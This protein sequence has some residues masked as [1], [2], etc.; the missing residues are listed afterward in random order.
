MMIP[1][2]A[3]QKFRESLRGPSL[4]P[5]EPG[6]DEVRAIPNAMINRKPAII[7]RCAGAAD[8]ISC[9]R[10]GREHDLLVSIR[11][12]GHSV[13][14]K[15]VCDDGLMIDLSAMKGI[16]V[17]PARR[18]VRA[19]P[20]LRLGEFDRETQAL[21]L[22]TTMGLLP[23][24]GISGLTLGGG[25]GNLMAKHGLALDNLIGVDVVTADGRLLTASAD[26][27]EDLFWGIRGSSGNLGVVTSLEYRL[28]EV[29]PVLGGPLLYPVN[30]AEEVV[31]FCRDFAETLPDEV[32]LQ[33]GAFTLPDGMKVFAM[34]VCYCGSSLSE[35][36]KILQPMRN[37]GSPIAD[38]ISTMSYVQMQ[39]LFEP[40]FPLGLHTYVKSNFLQQL[41]NEAIETIAEWAGK[42]PSPHTFAPFI[43]HWHGAATRVGVSDTAFP[44]R[45][46]A[47]N[48]M[49]WSV[50][51]DPSDT[52]KNIQWTRDCWAAMQPFLVEGSYVNYQ[53]D[54][55]QAVARSAYGP[56][57][58]R[59][60]VLKAKYDPTNFFRMNHNISP[61][62]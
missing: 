2:P 25:F 11:G 43:E 5:G 7:A 23:N 42:S 27:N 45:R 14:G 34:A 56:N 15:S 9:V 4:C 53:S 52:D 13:A 10:F 39:S 17:D 49:A 16:R 29:G 28:H 55:G 35:G 37:F 44:H 20:G 60:A 59:L 40:F 3:I 54:E 33:A 61:A 12:G 62:N 48:V 47:W 6:Y 26:E 50:W 57:Y 21:G 18:T 32:V 22:A 38:M 36:E 8:V 30:K 24:T 31:R 58:D 1:Q 19:E 46:P 51:K 41:S